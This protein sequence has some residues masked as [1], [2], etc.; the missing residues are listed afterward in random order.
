MAALAELQRSVVDDESTAPVPLRTVVDVVAGARAAG[1]TV[2]WGA[3]DGVTDVHPAAYRLVQEALTN[4][5][6]HAPGAAARVTLRRAGDR[7]EVEVHNS[8]PP[9]P[10]RSDLP[11]GSGLA[12]LGRRV[13]QCGGRLAWGAQADGGFTVS[14]DFPAAV[15]A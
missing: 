4:V 6:R 10:A 9:S 14:A 15:R 5:F 11:G 2:E 7:L 13:E 3:D 1:L 12:G 8:A